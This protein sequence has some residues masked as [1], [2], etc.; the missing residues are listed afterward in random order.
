VQLKGEYLN[1]LSIHQSSLNDQKQ[2]FIEL[3][4][5]IKMKAELIDQ[6]LVGYVGSEQVKALKVLDHI[7]KKLKKALEKK[8]EIGL[9][10]IEF[11]K[12]QLFPNGAL[13]ERSENYLN[14]YF[15]NTSLIKDLLDEFEPFEFSFNLFWE[16]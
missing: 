11:V 15:N 16:E 12:D 2:S 9:G 14:F 1:R 5:T 8:H 13:Q 7:A 10:Q 4:K 6:S 3:F